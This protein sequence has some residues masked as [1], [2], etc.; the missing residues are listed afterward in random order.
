MRSA[1]RSTTRRAPSHPEV[2]ER[3]VVLGRV[4]HHLAPV[5]GERR[6]A[7]GEGLARRT[8]RGPRAPPT[9]NGHAA[10]PAGWAVLAAAGHDDVGAGQLVDAVVGHGRGVIGR[11]GRGRARSAQCGDRGRRPDE[12]VGFHGARRATLTCR[13]RRQRSGRARRSSWSTLVPMTAPGRTASA[14]GPNWAPNDASSSHDDDV[15]PEADLARVAP[16]RRAVL[17]EGGP[18]ARPARRAGRTAGSS[19]RPCAATMRGGAPLAG[20]AD[21]DRQLGLHRPGLAAGLGAARRGRPSRVGRPRRAAGYGR[22]AAVLVEQVEA[23]ADRRERDAERLV[24]DLRPAGA[25]ADLGPPAGQVVDGRDGLGQHAGVPV[26]GA[27]D[28]AAARARWSWRR[29]ARCARRPPRGTRSRRQVG[30]VEVVPDRDRRRSRAPRR[31]RH[32]SRSSS[33]VVFCSPVWTPKVV[34]LCTGTVTRRAAA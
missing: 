7:V 22:A 2:G 19:R 18:L 29:R 27:V 23:L 25:E 6:P 24:L 15:D 12:R 31:R 20:A 1:H 10:R 30:R 16:E 9:Q 28:E 4:Q 32:R 5:V 17:G 14:R 11:S 26:A 13:R 3:G 21:P 34:T 8:A 33:T